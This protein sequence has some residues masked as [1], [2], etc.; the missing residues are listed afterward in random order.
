MKKLI[1]IILF[2]CSLPV[3]LKA[4]GYIQMYFHQ[5]PALAANAGHDTLVC[6]GSPIQLG[7]A[8]TAA[9]GSPSY[10]YLWSPAEGLDDPTSPNPLAT[11]DQTVTYKL[12]VNDLSGCQAIQFV[13]VRVDPCLGIDN[14]NLNE[15]LSIFPNPSGGNFSIEGLQSNTSGKV[16]IE[17]INR[18]GQVVYRKDFEVGS[19]SAGLMV[20]SGITEP[21]MYF[22]S[23][24]L[25]ENV[26]TKRVMIR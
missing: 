9:G 24:R 2:I 25:N 20:D 7:G 10:I 3:G 16:T 23:I 22:L 6:K 8:P 1:Y 21:G 12:T 26:F 11:P 18:L 4:Q 15:T 13:T 17:M 5:P 14:R 19:L